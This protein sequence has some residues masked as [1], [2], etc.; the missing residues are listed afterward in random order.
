MLKGTL[1]FFIILFFFATDFSAQFLLPPYYL[2]PVDTFANYYSREGHF[3]HKDSVDYVFFRP[4]EIMKY[5]KAFIIV[6]GETKKTRHLIKIEKERLDPNFFIAD[7]DN[8]SLDEMIFLSTGNHFLK[9]FYFNDNAKKV[10]FTLKI[11]KEQFSGDF[12]VIPAQIDDDE[13][14]EII[15]VLAPS[16]PIKG[17]I[18]GMFAIDLD[19]K[20]VLWKKYFADFISSVTSFRKNGEDYAALFSFARG[21][22][23]FYANGK[24]YWKRSESSEEI[25]AIKNAPDYSCDSVAYLK[26]YKM[27]TGE[28]IYKKRLGGLGT[29]PI[30]FKN[31]IKN[32]DAI[33]K[34][35]KIADIPGSFSYLLGFKSENFA[36]DTLL[37]YPKLFSSVKR[38]VFFSSQSIIQIND[39]QM[40]VIKKQGLELKPFK[41]PP[42]TKLYHF[43]KTNIGYV[44]IASNGVNGMFFNENQELIAN[45]GNLL[46]VIYKKNSGD[47]FY[48]KFGFNRHYQTVFYRLKKAPIYSRLSTT[49]FL[50]LLIFLFV[51]LLFFIVLWAM[52]LIISYKRIHRQNLEIQAATSKLVHAEKLSALGTIAGSIAHQINSPLGAIINATNRLSRK[53]FEDANLKL[54]SE[55]SERIK[56]IVN[57]FLI[58]TH[59]SEEDEKR[60][61]TFNEV[62]ENWYQLFSIDFKHQLINIE[63]DIKDGKTV[64]PLTFNQLNEIINNLMFNA[65]D[66]V[67]KANPE[68]ERIIKISAYRE[69]GKFV[70]VIKDNGTGFDA[71]RL[72]EGIK[73]FATTKERGKGTG[74]GL[75][76]IQTILKNVSG[77]IILANH[78]NGAEVKVI[79]PISDG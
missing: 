4:A 17:S 73:I 11:P 66:A 32:Y 62:F 40:V 43:V 45:T 55:A 49:S 56:T 26:I 3:Y 70:I 19:T 51:F 25:Q 33:L 71:K 10:I 37:K 29:W 22:E 38:K 5:K 54:I 1:N 6:S 57:K 27:K 31:T 53:G 47:I 69:N 48:K 52:T 13:N 67:I 39:S 2:E 61:V 23:F 36:L 63:T 72:K 41:I 9:V 59:T 15:L 58:T 65:R 8:D 78:E 18:R 77:H 20:K 28:E 76:I 60:N 14:K 21:K 74:L 44:F 68:S 79:I 42:N 12:F 7:L 16:M 34:V 30:K 24:F 75:W 46:S 64:L 50:V 35:R